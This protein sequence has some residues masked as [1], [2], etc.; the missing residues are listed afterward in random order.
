[1]NKN[2]EKL[3]WSQWQPLPSSENCRQINGPKG[4]G[5][6][7]IRNSKTRQLIQFGIGGKCNDRM[8]SIF[9]KPYGTGNRNND[10]K[11]NYVLANW[12][13][14]E[15]RRLETETREEAARIQLVIESSKNHLFNI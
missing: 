11:R 12:F 8:K 3:N 2:Y 5:V 14:L 10:D 9:P 1:M 13:D 15:Y 7:Q 4:S 6:Y